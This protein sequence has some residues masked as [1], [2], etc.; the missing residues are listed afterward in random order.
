MYNKWRFFMPVSREDV[1]RHAGVSPATVS[2]VINNKD[3]V[4]DKLKRKVLKAVHELDY[5]PNLVARSLKTSKTNQIAL[6]SNDISNQYYAEI[7]IGMEELARYSGYTVNMINSYCNRK[8]NIEKILERQYDGIIWITDKIDVNTLNY[9]AERNFPLIFIGNQKYEG[10]DKSI[11]EVNIEIY[12]GA[13]ALFEYLIKNGHKRIGYISPYSLSSLDE[14]D[15]RLNAYIDILNKYGI[16]YDPSIVFWNGYGI[17]YVYKSALKMIKKEKFPTA[18]FSGND[19]FALPV[20]S[21]INKAGLKI[22][23]D[24]S[25]AGFDNLAVSRYISPSLTTVD[26][27]KYNLGKKLMEL[28]IKKINGEEIKNVSLQTKLIIRESTTRTN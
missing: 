20:I 27:P 18:I 5:H 16:K 28:L 15:Y 4:S 10:L 26:M 1:A 9:L 21:A 13:F 11:T 7:V 12:N 17:D 25:V 6:I 22:P 23:D 24:I 14:H 19:Y 8:N 2:N 3:V